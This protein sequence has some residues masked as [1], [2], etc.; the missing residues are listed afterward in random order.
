MKKRL[1][2]I[3]LTLA[4]VVSL[5]PTVYAGPLDPYTLTVTTDGHGTAVID[6][7]NATT[8]NF[9]NALAQ[10]IATASTGYEFEKWEATSNL[11]F[12]GSGYSYTTATTCFQISSNL[13]LTAHFKAKTYTVTL[14][15]QS[16]TTPGTTSVT[17]TYDSAMPSITVPTRTGYTFGGYYTATNGGGTQYYK[18]D[19]TSAR[20]W[21]IASNTTLYAHWTANPATVTTAPTAKSLTYSGSAQALVNAGT[22]SNGTMYYKLSGGSYSASI[23]TATNAGTYTVNYQAQGAG[24]NSAE[25]SLSVTIGQKEVGLS[26]SNTSFTYDGGSHVPTA[27]ATGL[28]GGTSC[29]VTVTGAQT[30]AGSCTATASGLSNSNYK[31]PSAK[32]TSF[33]ISKATQSIFPVRIALISCAKPGRSKFVPVRPLSQYIFTYSQ[34]VNPA[35]EQQK[36]APDFS[37]PQW[38]PLP[39]CRCP[40]AT[41]AHSRPRR[42]SAVYSPWASPLAVRDCAFATSLPCHISPFAAA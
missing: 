2:S 31:L 32:T 29:T 7:T 1:T 5:A 40:P 17:A 34:A 37:V 23:P 16:A 8:Y 26:W 22:A 30:N 20:T 11:N 25:G 13:T 6:G 39:V 38:Y 4:M 42:I 27:T 19:G 36:H 3:L 9:P 21:N 41:A 12:A 24:G 10:V 14:N 28:V 18:A 15:N 33:T 35:A